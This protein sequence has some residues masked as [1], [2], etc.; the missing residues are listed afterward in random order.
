MSLENKLITIAENIPKIY[1]AGQ[2]SMVDESKLI[3]KTVSGNPLFLNDVSDIPHKVSCKVSSKNLFNNDTSLLKE[4]NFTA[5]N[6]TYKRV[7]YEIE[8]P[9]GTYTIRAM[10]KTENLSDLYIYGY[11]LDQNNNVTKQTH[12]VVGTEYRTV[13]FTINKGEKL[14]EV[15]GTIN[16]DIASATSLFNKF[17]IMLEKGTTATPYTP[18]VPDISAATLRVSGYGKNLFNNDASLVKPVTYKGKTKTY[19]ENGREIKLPAGIYT[20]SAH[21]PS[22]YNQYIYVIVNDKNGEFVANCMADRYNPNY[23]KS[24]NYF[25][26]GTPDI[27]TVNIKVNDGDTL[28]LYDAISSHTLDYSKENVF[29]RANIQL[30]AGEKE[31]EYEPY[32]GYEYPVPTDGLIA[33]ILNAS[34]YMNMYCD[35]EGILLEATYNKSYGIDKRYESI[36]AEGFNEGA[37]SEY[38]RFWDA[39]QAN[40]KPMQYEYKFAAWGNAVFTPKYDI[41][42]T[43]GYSGTNTFYQSGVTNIAEVLEERGLILDTS[44]CGYMSSMF[45]NAKTVRIPELNCS[46]AHEYNSNGLYMTFYGATKLETIDKLVVTEKLKYYNSFTNC[47]SLK[48]IVFEGVIAY[49]IGF[50]QSPLSKDSITSIVN[51]LS[52]TTTGQALTLNKTAVNTAFGINVDDESTYPEGSE[53]YTLKHSKDNWTFSYV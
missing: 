7:G 2:K 4:L 1:E 37:Q 8:L 18:Y 39:Y 47:S 23:T 24:D 11:I 48:N 50:G 12:I 9:V 52:E 42:L 51:H 27:Y 28:Y 20:L 53:F 31:T 15:N 46:R 3:P 32:V 40:G 44:L 30:E 5:S 17:D 38:D 33:D 36:K 35:I 14:V 29:S 16:V 45:Q 19:T 25:I 43:V 22:D 26:A 13:T 34:P 6:G 10:P 21:V 41:V 49:N